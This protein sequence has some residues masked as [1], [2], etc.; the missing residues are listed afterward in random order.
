MMTGTTPSLPGSTQCHQR[1]GT[2]VSRQ[3]FILP[4]FGQFALSVQRVQALDL[5]RV[6]S[7]LDPQ[8]HRRMPEIVNPSDVLECCQPDAICGSSSDGAGHRQPRAAQRVRRSSVRHRAADAHR[9]GDRRHRV[10]QRRAPSPYRL[11]EGRIEVLR[12]DPDPPLGLFD[13]TRYREHPLR[14]ESGDR[15]LVGRL[16]WWRW[17]RQG[18]CRWRGRVG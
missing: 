11:R 6:G 18:W 8:R 9:P 10:D 14:L 12:T 5:S 17:P 15:L 13:D 3:V 16:A 4:G 2:R 7:R 1:R